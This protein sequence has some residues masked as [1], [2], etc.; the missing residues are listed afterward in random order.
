MSQTVGAGNVTVD[1]TPWDKPWPN[2][3]YDS[4]PF[5]EGLEQH[6]FLM[7]QCNVCKSWYWP[8]AYC[9]KC[10]KPDPNFGTMSW[11]EASGRGTVFSWNIIYYVFHKGF[12]E[13]VPY[14][15]VVVETEEGPLVSSTLVQ[16]DPESVHVGM[17]VE[18]VFEDHPQDEFT[19][20]RFRPRQA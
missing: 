18:V 1:N 14:A 16:C 15:Q 19:M 5:W 2:V 4:L 20:L 12:A 6:K 3:D 10:K 13:D 7:F 8:K 9:V 17:P 11:N